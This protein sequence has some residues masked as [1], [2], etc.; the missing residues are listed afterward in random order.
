MIL[1]LGEVQEQNKE[2]EAPVGKGQRTT[3]QF[4]LAFVGPAQPALPSAIYRLEHRS[5]DVD[6]YLEDTGIDGSAR[7]YRARFTVLR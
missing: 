1:D 3:K 2:S 6:I 7:R 4:S 5:A